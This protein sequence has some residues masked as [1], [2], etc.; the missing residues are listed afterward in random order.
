[1]LAQLRAEWDEARATVAATLLDRQADPLWK[2]LTEFRQPQPER[3]ADG[4]CVVEIR[5]LPGAVVETVGRI[6]KTNRSVSILAHAGNG[7]V[8]AHVPAAAISGLRSA[9]RAA[10]GSLVVASASASATRDV[11]TVWG[12]PPGGWTVMQALKSRFDPKGILNRGRFLVADG[13]R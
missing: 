3:I 10:G 1:M 8:L 6:L 11:A 12:P 2:A 9:V 7:V 4:S 13:C 5:V